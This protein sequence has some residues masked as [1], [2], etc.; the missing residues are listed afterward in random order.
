MLENRP[1]RGSVLGQVVGP[2]EG[3]FRPIIPRHIGDLFVVRRYY[4][5]LQE[6]AGL[7][8]LNR[9][10]DQRFAVEESQVF[11]G[12]T[13][14]ASTRTDSPNYYCFSSIH[15]AIRQ[16]FPVKADSLA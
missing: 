13:F 1:L 3:H 7:S 8:A 4:Y 2:H 6:R 16:T 14:G 12:D 5:A 10:C 9:M 15:S 11:S